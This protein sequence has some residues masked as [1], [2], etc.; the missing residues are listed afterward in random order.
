MLLTDKQWEIFKP[1]LAIERKSNRGCPS[2]D[3]RDVF[4]ALLFVLSTDIQWRFLPKP[5]PPKS[6]VHDSLK[7]W[8][9]RDAFRRI[10]AQIVRQLAKNGRLQLDEC[11]IDAT[12][13]RA[14]GGG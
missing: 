3:T 10:L 6:T 9:Q 1:I 14:G 4:E 13:V 2:E 5:F 8:S 7:I 11:S 12:F